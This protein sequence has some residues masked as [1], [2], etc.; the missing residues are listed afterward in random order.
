MKKYIKYIVMAVLITG[1]MTFNSC[2]DLVETPRDKVTSDV[3]VQ[4]PSMIPNLIAPALGKLRIL[5]SKDT[6][7]GLQEATSDE[8]CFPTRG[9]DWFDNGVWQDY[10]LHNWAPINPDVRDTWNILSEGI[11]SA[12]FGISVLGTQE[13]VSPKVLEYRGMLRFLKDYY[14]YCFVDLFGVSPSRDP[15]NLDY[16]LDPSFLSRK[17]AFN[18]VTSDLKQIIGNMPEKAVA[19]YGVPNKDAARMLLAK[20]YINKEVFEGQA[21]WD[22]ALIY[23]NQIID[24]GKYQL[25]NN[26]FNMFG[27]DNH[28]NAGN[29]DDEA[30]FV[31]TMDDGDDYGNDGKI[32][33]VQI[34]FHYN[35]KLM[36][37]YV[38][39]NGAMA[40]EDYLNDCWI[41]GTDLT[42][43]VRWVDSTIYPV[44]A[45]VNGFNQGQQY[46]I[47]GKALKTRGGQPLFFTKEC[48]LDG[49]T[50]EQGYRVLKYA[51]RNV[52]VNVSRTP[53]D[54]LI[55]RYAD[56]LLMK[57]ECLARK[58]DM[59]GALTFVNQ[60]REKRK[61]PA[62]ASLQLPDILKERGRELYW[63][64]HRRQ[65]MIRFGTFLLPKT[66]KDFTSPET[67][68]L[69]PIP[70]TAIEASQGALKQNPGY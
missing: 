59:S 29:T 25:A 23:L 30:I 38:N 18:Y 61:A 40:P 48:P 65:D 66:N 14:M 34:T 17:E 43:D 70:Q 32:S 19:D 8:L 27:P 6:Y 69:I 37:A 15:F 7:W 4:D 51:P 57:A 21:A 42:K 24:P 55:W 52:P 22:S 60:L 5:W 13:N 54:Y 45:V 67:A 9:T 47:T 3:L 20:M 10:Y 44:M 33:W 1:S 58:G 16:T 53:N 28:L 12:N 41:N 50:E 2:T 63:E 26:Y 11:A 62:L 49:A 39:W 64:G 31:A 36:G 56:A 35:Q 46:D 68:L